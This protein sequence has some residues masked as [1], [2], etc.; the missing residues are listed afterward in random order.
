M[1]PTNE[2]ELCSDD[3]MNEAIKKGKKV[4]IKDNHVVVT[5]YIFNNKIYIYDMDN[6]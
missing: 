3:E 4:I 1:Y 5:A 2:Q 6:A